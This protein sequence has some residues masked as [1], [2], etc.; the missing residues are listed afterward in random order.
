[1][2]K[3]KLSLIFILV[4]FIS[5]FIVSY[6]MLDLGS[7]K[8][9]DTT[10][11]GKFIKPKISTYDYQI[12]IINVRKQSH[13]FLEKWTLIYLSENNCDRVCKNDMYLLKQIHIALG[14]DMNRVQRMWMFN[15]NQNQEV[16]KTLDQSLTHLNEK[17]PNLHLVSGMNLYKKL[18]ENILGNAKIFLVDPLGNIIL[19]YQSNFDGKKLFKDLKKLL[20]FSKIG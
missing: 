16:S 5:P 7:G 13:Q 1:M 11:Y 15:G 12:S 19:M 4:L 6:I 8:T 18:N 20:K 3:Q 17:Y 2:P 9:M 14:K 10:N